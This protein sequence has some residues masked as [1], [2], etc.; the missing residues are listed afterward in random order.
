M[1]AWTQNHLFEWIRDHGPFA[2]SEERSKA[3]VDIFDFV[4]EY[5]EV[6]ERGDSWTQILNLATRTL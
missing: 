1:D 4:R 2:T 6:I 5:P 3:Y